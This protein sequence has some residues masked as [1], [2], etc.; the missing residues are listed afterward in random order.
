VLD[1]GCGTGEHTLMAASLGLDATGVDVSPVAIRMA[2]EKAAA[3]GVAS[4]RFV[5]G[6]VLLPATLTAL[7]GPYDTIID[8]AVFHSV[9]DEDRPA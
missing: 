3:R 1:V 6:D 7:G 5:T 8:R 4:A 2:Q 9:S